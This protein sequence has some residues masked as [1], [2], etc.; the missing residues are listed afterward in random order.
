[1]FKNYGGMGMTNP[2]RV[3]FIIYFELQFE[4]SW[5]IKTSCTVLPF[6][7]AKS[8]SIMNYICSRLQRKRWKCISPATGTIIH[9]ELNKHKTNLTKNVLITIG[10][11]IVFKGK[12][13]LNGLN[14]THID[15]TLTIIHYSHF[16]HCRTVHFL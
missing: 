16:L 10:A 4:L 14:A 13:D 11:N 12:C 15:S 9:Q 7:F 3:F 2:M 5:L 8:I 6:L 1:M